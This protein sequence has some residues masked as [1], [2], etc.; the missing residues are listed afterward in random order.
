MSCSLHLLIFF[1]WV[2][3][4]FYVENLWLAIVFN[5]EVLSTQW[6][7]I[8]PKIKIVSILIHIFLLAKFDWL[9]YHHQQQEWHSWK[10][11]LPAR[12]IE[13]N[14]VKYGLLCV[15]DN[16]HCGQCGEPRRKKPKALLSNLWR[17]LTSK[18]GVSIFTKGFI[19]SKPAKDAAKHWD[20][21]GKLAWN[22]GL[23][24]L[25]YWP[26]MTIYNSLKNWLTPYSSAIGLDCVGGSFVNQFKS[27]VKRVVGAVKDMRLELLLPFH[28]TLES[29][30]V[31]SQCTWISNLPYNYKITK[32]SE[33]HVI[34][35]ISLWPIW[36]INK[37]RTLDELQDKWYVYLQFHTRY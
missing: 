21:S 11:S 22:R 28:L 3:S 20:N 7:S 1:V 4:E 27:E 29:P 34:L 8:E 16:L 6:Q 17:P 12:V 15:S 18:L 13:I 37:N 30:A 32:A 35:L 36:T 10:L 33:K 24:H 31:T 9:L 23:R 14:I 2:P 19:V 25:T 26:N 5:S